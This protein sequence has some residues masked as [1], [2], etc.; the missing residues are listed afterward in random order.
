MLALSATVDLCD[1]VMTPMSRHGVKEVL[2]LSRVYVGDIIFSDVPV[3]SL[4]SGEASS[5]AI[6]GAC[7]RGFI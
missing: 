7:I 4:N 1:P 6:G 5:T 2:P 3:V